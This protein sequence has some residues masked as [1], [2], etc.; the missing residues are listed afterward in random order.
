MSM[1]RVV[2]SEQKD[3]TDERREFEAGRSTGRLWVTK[4][5]PAAT[6]AELAHLHEFY[7]SLGADAEQWFYC[8]VSA[9]TAAERVYF[10]IVPD[11]DGSRR[12]AKSFWEF[13]AWPSKLNDLSSEFAEGFVVGALEAWDELK[14]RA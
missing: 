6:A 2:L 1:K 9:F 4:K 13:T 3:S 8:V 7:A 11:R 10:V 14:S 5:E 12:E